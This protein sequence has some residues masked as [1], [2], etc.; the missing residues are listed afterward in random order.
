[1]ERSRYSAGDFLSELP[2]LPVKH[3]IVFKTVSHLHTPVIDT[4]AIIIIIIIIITGSAVLINGEGQNLTPQN[5]N[6]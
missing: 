3:R 1:M 6:S 5:R 2:W 4:Y